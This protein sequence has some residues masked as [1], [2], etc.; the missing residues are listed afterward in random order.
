[1]SKL[2]R[3]NDA[4]SGLGRSHERSGLERADLADDPIEQFAR[5]LQEALEAGVLL[6]NAMTLATADERGRVSARTVLLKGVD[7]RGFQ[8]FTNY[9]SNKGR[10]LTANP[11]GALAWHWID[12]ERQVS[13]S[14]PVARLS[15]EESDDYFATR[16]RGS[17]LAA[18]A[19]RQ[20]D[21][22][23]SRAELDARVAEVRR[24]FPD[25]I[26][27]PPHW[28]GYR[29]TPRYVEFWQARD[30]RLHDRFRYERAVSD[31]PWTIRRLS[32]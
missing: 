32:P 26:P 21:E 14:G 8:F 9:R 5:W 13:T 19:S 27:R 16:P 4:I 20:S 2:E 25:E 31:A 3:V 10:D 28:G 30:D 22:I 18:W 1:M 29:L 23:G 12:L 6:P 17:K 15:D 24:R 7:P 11:E